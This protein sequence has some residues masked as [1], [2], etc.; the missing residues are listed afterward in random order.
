MAPNSGSM[1][2]DPVEVQW[3]QVQDTWDYIANEEK[4]DR[5][6]IGVYLQASVKKGTSDEL[7]DALFNAIEESVSDLTLFTQEEV[8]ESLRLQGFNVI[9][10][11]GFVSRSDSPPDRETGEDPHG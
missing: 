4:S 9:L 2:S 11:S 6:Y 5:T 10:T 8:D 3:T 1:E 7:I